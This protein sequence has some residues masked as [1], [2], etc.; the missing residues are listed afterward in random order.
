MYNNMEGDTLLNCQHNPRQALPTVDRLLH[1]KT[2]AKTFSNLYS[3]ILKTDVIQT[4]FKFDRSI[5]HQTMDNITK[6]INN[7]S[8]SVFLPFLYNA[9]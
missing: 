7:Y 8:F 6:Q 4:G 5:G 9:V 2:Y 1:E 3:S